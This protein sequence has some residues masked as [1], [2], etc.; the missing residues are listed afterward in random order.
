MSRAQLLFLSDLHS[1]SPLPQERRAAL[2][3]ADGSSLATGSPAHLRPL[4]RSLRKEYPDTITVSVGDN[5]TA[6]PYAD[7]AASYEKGAELLRLL[8]IDI[9]VV[10]NHDLDVSV[11]TLVSWSTD[12][13]PRKEEFD[14]HR[15][16]SKGRPWRGLPFGFICANLMWKASREPVFP[17]HTVHMVGDVP[18]GII[19]TTLSGPEAW[20]MSWNADLVEITDPLEAVHREAALLER[21][22]VRCVVVCHHDG[23]RSSP[24]ILDEV[25]PVPGP[26]ADLAAAT[27]ANVAAV[28][29]GHTHELVHMSVARSD[30]STLP[31]LIPASHGVAV[32]R[33]RIE[34]DAHGAFTEV[35]ADLVPVV[36]EADSDPEV[37][38]VEESW[39][40]RMGEFAKESIAYADQPLTCAQDEH[41]QHAVGSIAAD[42]LLW[43][44]RLDETTFA[45]IALLATTPRSDLFTGGS[46]LGD[47]ASTVGVMPHTQVFSAFGNDAWLLT[48]TLTGQE[49]LDIL[50]SVWPADVSTVERT[51]ARTNQAETAPSLA[52]AGMEI[53]RHRSGQLATVDLVGAN[54]ERRPLESGAAYRVALCA[55]DAVRPHR[56]GVPDLGLA[57]DLVRHHDRDNRT[58]VAYLR[59]LGSVSA[60][61]PRI[62]W[63][64]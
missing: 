35:C 44:A 3:R 64:A 53:S 39:L 21:K 37:S 29:G 32:G 24:D 51:P 38:A 46:V 11:P 8:D 9:S 18:I 27:P 4:L 6:Y 43:S 62:R 56:T 14:R 23:V 2:L 28:I 60:P 47:L 48:G 19:G 45:E 57:R 30:G 31:V 1:A 25:T 50:T 15:T 40:H 63:V 52:F 42:A 61:P 17:S 12:H 41:R 36:F 49:I 7:K 10:G 55:G 59:Q 16:D 13:H 34:F 5:F 26:L 33:L 22:G 20:P 58:L 54:S